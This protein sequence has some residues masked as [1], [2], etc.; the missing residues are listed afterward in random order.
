MKSPELRKELGKKLPDYVLLSVSALLFLFIWN[1]TSLD[2]QESF[3]IGWFAFTTLRF[4]NNLGHT[5]CIFDFLTFYSAMDTLVSP[6]ITYKFFGKNNPMSSLWG[7]YMRVPEETYFAYLI[8]ANI[9]LFIGLHLVYHK[10]ARYALP[11]MD[12]VRT[13]LSDKLIVGIVFIAVGLVASVFSPLVP[14]SLAYVFNLLSMLPYLGGFYIYFSLKRR[15]GLTMSIL[16]AVFFLSAARSGLFGE[17]V[18]YAVLSMCLVMSQYK[19]KFL[20]KLSMFVGG[21]FLILV[22]Q[23]AK[24]EYRYLTWSGGSQIGND[25]YGKDN[26]EIFFD[27]TSERLTHPSEIF[28]EESLFQLNRRFNQ[29]W[30]ISLAM[31]YVPRVE[32]YANGETIL[33][34]LEAVVVP[35]L[36]WPD[37]PEAGGAYNLARFVGFK[38][39]L[40][41][42]MNIGPYGEGYGN[43]GA[44]GGVI[45]V[46]LYS[47][48]IAYFL[49][50]TLEKCREYPS[51]IVW[52]P[53]L[54]YY[55]LT[56]ETDILTTINSFIK[57]IVFIY[58][59][60]IAAK[61]AYKIDI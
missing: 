24:A 14:D 32:P 10:K 5:V 42:S 7:A 41:Y 44:V 9:A 30:L 26:L 18:M 33:L 57:S 58:L 3:I 28:K 15:R 4:I 8:P 11:Y 50:K 49:H 60:Y 13:Y 12:K 16:I 19:I 6:L 43:F 29:G 47:I 56:V 1:T 51:L 31:N 21:F 53:L 48:L 36:L 54:F 35:R 20:T 38:K 52:I 22:L 17:F 23:S 40:S 61:K 59:I 25:Y 55:V 37:K 27:L 34:S 45:F 2:L 39:K 46:L